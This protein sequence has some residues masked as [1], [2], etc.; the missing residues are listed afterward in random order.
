MAGVGGQASQ[1]YVNVVMWNS[2][3]QLETMSTHCTLAQDRLP[4][5]VAP[6]ALPAFLIVRKPEIAVGFCAPQMHRNTHA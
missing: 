6:K 1:M 3:Q 4:P 5:G 2:R